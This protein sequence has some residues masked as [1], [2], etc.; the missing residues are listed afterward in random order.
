[1]TRAAKPGVNHRDWQRKCEALVTE[2]LL[3]LGLLS[4]TQVKQQDPAN[5]ACRT[6][7]MHG[8]GHHLGLGVH[9]LG[10]SDAPFA[11][12]NVLTIEPGIYI[13][14]EG[15]GIRLENDIVITR[16]KGGARNLFA[17]VPIEAD[18]IE[19][20]MAR[21]QRSGRPAKATARH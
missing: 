4:R 17:D 18:E 1:M 10:G 21:A 13:A 7:F 8:C 3:S 12:G 15:F 5:P 16:G 14:E 9:D 6:Y 2:E 11:P 20:L 19:E